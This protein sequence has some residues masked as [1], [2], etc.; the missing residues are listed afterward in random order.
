MSYQI[1]RAGRGYNPV[2]AVTPPNAG[3]DTDGA[4]FYEKKSWGPGAGEFR[5]TNARSALMAF[6]GHAD[7][8]GWADLPDETFASLED[9]EDWI[10]KALA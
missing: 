9:I 1:I 8:W 10:K 6:S 4:R 7:G 5:E 3:P 2:I